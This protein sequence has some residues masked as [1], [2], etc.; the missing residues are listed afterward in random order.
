W[1]VTD[2]SGNT[3]MA[4]Q[5]VTVTDNVNPTITAPA[6]VSAF[7]NTACTATGVALGTPVTADNC[8]VASV[9]NNAPSAFALG[10]TTVIWTVTDG[11]GNTAMA[12]QIVTVTDNVNPTITAPANL[13][14]NTNAGCT[15]IN[16]ALG[17]PV[18][19]DNCTVASVTNNAP[20]I[21]PKGNT[22]VTWTVT[23]G[24]G[25]TAMASQ[26]VTVSDNV[27]PLITAPAN[28][29][30][31]INSGC[32]ASNVVLGT[33][34]TSDNCTVASVSKNSPT[35]YYSGVTTV[36]WTVTDGSG[37][38]ATAA[39][40][41][42]VIENKK[43]TINAPSSITVNTNSACT[44][45]NVVLGT[46]VTNDNCSVASVTNNAPL[47]FPKGNTT[48]IWTVTD[49]SGNT[50]TAKQTVKVIDNVPP[51]AI[52]KNVTVNLVN[53]TASLLPQDV[54]NGSYDNCGIASYSLSKTSFNC[55]NI[56]P[57]TVKLTVEDNSENTAYCYVTVTVAGPVTSCNITAVSTT[58][59][60]TG[61]VPSKIFLG[62]GPQ[63]VI[64]NASVSG[65]TGFTYSWSGPSGL[66]S[67]TD[68][69][70]VFTP[71][72]AGNYQFTLTATNSNGCSAS[73]SIT[74]R[75]V[76]IRVPGFIGSK[77][78]L[79]HTTTGTSSTNQKIAVALSDVPTHIPGHSGDHLG[80][81]EEN[82]D[83]NSGEN[84]GDKS[85]LIGQLVVAPNAAFETLVFPNPFT[86]EI[87]LTIESANT[88]AA[89]I[90]I[91]DLTGKIAGKIENA[92]SNVPVMFG[93]DLP[94]GIYIVNVRQG[95]T[96]QKV[97]IVKTR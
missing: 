12:S 67:T 94:N 11:S 46:P 84:H 34:V 85:S 42:S 18:T 21:F 43:P 82:D 29:S 47:A 87:S 17:T 9:T 68:A 76:D 27:N 81:C 59:A 53:G 90:T 80:S 48:V 10:N 33:P 70:P 86:N 37:N 73:A 96:F 77:V 69:S 71:V 91:F 52:G 16:V 57:Y 54:D 64:L 2:G 95:D 66:S 51:V 75:V 1:T 38:T 3:A 14:A 72:S 62:Y 97:K 5:I 58:G 35:I 49:A 23:D 15:A 55:S 74:I 22:T 65:G 45:T 40:L 50:A 92:S 88:D 36:I 79:C 56:G 7:T 89:T 83:D 60:F 41:V 32:T 25:N 26:I 20:S 6:S 30:I 63:S 39:Q 44:A 24:S 8:S 28:V 78:Y 61:D 19:A 31:S 93:N 4:S 13:N